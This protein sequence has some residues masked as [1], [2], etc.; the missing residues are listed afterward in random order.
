MRRDLKESV[1][2]KEGG[3]ER[4]QGRLESGEELGQVPGKHTYVHF[5]LGTIGRGHRK[6]V[7]SDVLFCV[8]LLKSNSHIIKRTLLKCLNQWLSAYS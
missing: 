2:E 4:G 8:V 5:V 1:G 3:Q 6:S 7:N